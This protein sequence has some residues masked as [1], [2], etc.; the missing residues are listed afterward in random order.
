MFK[1][2]FI[3]ELLIVDKDIQTL[4]NFCYLPP[5]HPAAKSIAITLMLFNAKLGIGYQFYRQSSQVRN[6]CNLATVR[7][8]DSLASHL[9]RT[10]PGLS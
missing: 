4:A 1:M 8:I 2:L 5:M 3:G 9:F 6:L 7:L 10:V